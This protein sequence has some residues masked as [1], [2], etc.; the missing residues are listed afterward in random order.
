MTEVLYSSKVKPEHLAR[1]AIVVC[2]QKRVDEKRL[3]VASWWPASSL[4]TSCCITG[5]RLSAGLRPAID[6]AGRFSE[7]LH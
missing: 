6:G 1:K 5:T 2:R 7:N 4:R 3:D